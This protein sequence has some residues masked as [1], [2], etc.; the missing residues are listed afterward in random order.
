MRGIIFFVTIVPYFLF[1]VPTT[2]VHLGLCVWRRK[3]PV[4]G[5]W[6][7]QVFLYRRFLKESLPYPAAPDPSHGGEKKG[8]EKGN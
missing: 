4:A 6:R 1:C 7:D 2:F 5:F 8:G 3:R